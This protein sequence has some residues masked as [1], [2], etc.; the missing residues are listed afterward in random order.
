MNF[1][2]ALSYFTTYLARQGT[3]NVP[4]HDIS[5]DF[6]LITEKEDEIWYLKWLKQP[7]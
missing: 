1:L 7:F 5:K 3:A 4:W 2:I 6:A